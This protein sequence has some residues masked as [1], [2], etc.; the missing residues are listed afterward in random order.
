MV[1]HCGPVEKDR[2]NGL[3]RR[4]RPRLTL[5]GITFPKGLGAHAH[6]DVS[7]S[8]GWLHAFKAS[9]GLD[10]EVRLE[11]LAHLRGL[12]RRQQGV[13]LGPDDGGDGDGGDRPRALGSA[14]Q[15]RLVIGNGNGSLSRT[16]A[17][18]RSRGPS[19]PRDQYVR[20]SPLASTLTVRH[21][22]PRS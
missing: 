18:G 8:P 2:S 6:S 3:R 1:N 4:R 5:N 7:Y 11:R 15:L 10:D 14:G 12:S 16:T 17:T 13:R 22:I 9:V 19:A 20:P 21:R